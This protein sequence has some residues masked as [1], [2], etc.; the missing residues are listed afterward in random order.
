MR[1]RVETFVVV[2]QPAGM[3]CLFSI[4]GAELTNEHYDARAVMGGAVSTLAMQLTE[5]ST[6][7]A[8]IRVANRFFEKSVS[9]SRPP[10]PFASVAQEI[11]YKRGCVPITALAKQTGLSLRQFERNF[12]RDI[13]V[14]PK[15]YARIARFEAAVHLK[16]CSPTVSWTDIACQL[17][18]YDQMHMVHD[19]RELAGDNPTSIAAQ[20][21]PFIEYAATAEL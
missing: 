13:G 8:R 16:N 12:T 5:T 14:R 10:G 11:I 18:Y 15:L 19:F 21:E 9:K 7:G 3:Q 17:G 4:P 2:F 6:F 20:L 1:G